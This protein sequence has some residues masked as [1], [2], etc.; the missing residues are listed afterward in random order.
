M[1]PRPGS[2]RDRRAVLAQRLDQAREPLSQRLINA[3]RPAKRSFKVV[4]AFRAAA[5]DSADRKD[6]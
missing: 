6:D 4:G 3:R 2:P 1:Q 5:R